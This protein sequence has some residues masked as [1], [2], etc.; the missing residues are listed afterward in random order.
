MIWPAREPRQL[1]PRIWDE[2]KAATR[3]LA[4]PFRAGAL[5]TAGEHGVSQRT[6]ILRDVIPSSR[7][8]VCFTDVRSAKV[9]QLRVDPRASWLFYHPA[10]KV[11]L[12]CEGSLRV[13]HG[14]ELAR[15]Y[16]E[17]VPAENRFNYASASPPGTILAVSPDTA[18]VNPP[19]S[20]PK[21]EMEAA[22]S[23]FAVLVC[24]ITR[25]DWLQLGDDFHRRA[26]LHWREDNAECEANWVVP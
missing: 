22:W 14:E 7:G 19:G 3:S 21:E 11:Q 9:A 13:H 1:L 23:R 17:Q 15:R 18:S 26:V 10:D 8:L 25:I 4:H 5:A 6:L 24:R 2:L 20:S 16:W 12:V